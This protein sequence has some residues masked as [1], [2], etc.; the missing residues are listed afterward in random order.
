MA[1]NEKYA[2]L[3]KECKGRGKEIAAL[4]EA[5]ANMK[6]GKR[7]KEVEKAV[8]TGVKGCVGSWYTN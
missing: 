7:D 8:Q 1:T 6:K 3:S 2:T 5:V 4:C